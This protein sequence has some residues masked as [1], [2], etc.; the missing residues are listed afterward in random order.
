MCSVDLLGKNPYW[1]GY[2]KSFDKR[3]LVNFSA[4]I[5]SSTLDIELSKEMG[6]KLSHSSGSPFLNIGMAL[7][8]FKDEGNVPEFRLKLKM[9]TH[10]VG[11]S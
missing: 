9:S 11:K 4:T 5:F 10:P 8:C 6:L 7:H 3:W 2:S 1:W